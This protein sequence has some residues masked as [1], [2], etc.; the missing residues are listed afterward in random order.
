M[1]IFNR[2]Y[3]PERYRYG[4]CVHFDQISVEQ[5]LELLK[6]GFIDPDDTQNCSPTMQEFIDY[7]SDEPDKWYLHGYAI[8]PDRTDCRVTFEGIGSYAPLD[9]EEALDFIKYF[10]Y[11]DEVDAGT[12]TCAYCWYD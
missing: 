5:A 8:G 3:D 4:G 12:D 2:P 7:V 6:K 11:A 10:R 9:A 1:I